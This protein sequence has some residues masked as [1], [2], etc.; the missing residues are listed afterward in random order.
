MPAEPTFPIDEPAQICPPR[1]R[2]RPRMGRK[3][4]STPSVPSVSSSCK[5][6]LRAMR[7]PHNQV[8]RKYREGLNSD[9][10]R[11]RRAVPM[12]IQSNECML[13]GQ[14][15]PSKA[16]VLAGAIE[17]IKDI[18]RERDELREELGILNRGAKRMA[19]WKGA[20]KMKGRRQDSTT[21]SSDG[22][23]KPNTVF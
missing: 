16:M 13:I 3:L 14:P 1:K 10:E 8:E 5:P 11:L 22:E 6:Q 23:Y 9:L 7:Q 20:S 21:E 4:S 2:G 15:K 12:L 19:T 17:Y 18:E